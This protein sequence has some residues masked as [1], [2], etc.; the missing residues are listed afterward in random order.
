M[1]LTEKHKEEIDRIMSNM[2]DDLSFEEQHEEV[3]EAC[4]DDGV[5]DLSDD[6]EGDL[7]EEYSNLVWDYMEEKENDRNRKNY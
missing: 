5:F 7:Y 2:E 4:L 3:M 6:D 1:K